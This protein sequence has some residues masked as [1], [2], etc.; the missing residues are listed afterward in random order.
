MPPVVLSDLP[1]VLLERF[2]GKAAE[3]LL[4]MLVFLHPLTLSLI[5]HQEAR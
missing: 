1:G 3:S 5:T 4:R 2:E